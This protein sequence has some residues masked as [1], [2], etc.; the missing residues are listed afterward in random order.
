MDGGEAVQ[1]KRKEADL[2]GKVENEMKKKLSFLLHTFWLYCLLYY[3]EFP[4]LCLKRDAPCQLQI[5]CHFHFLNFPTVSSLLHIRKI[6]VHWPFLEKSGPQKWVVGATLALKQNFL[7]GTL[8][9][10]E[11]WL[12]LI[13]DLL[14][15]FS[16]MTLKRKSLIQSTDLI[17]QCIGSSTY[18]NFNEHIS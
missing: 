10:G 15:L 5:N 17:F 12:P 3:R 6:L 9:Y 14:R 7:A 16:L 18:I 8:F 4:L 2:D 11:L 13:R 1:K